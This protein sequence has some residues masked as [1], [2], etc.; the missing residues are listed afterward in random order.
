M[1]ARSSEAPQICVSRPYKSKRRATSRD[2]APSGIEFGLELAK[3][4]RRF[5]TVKNVGSRSAEF[6]QPE[7][8]GD[9]NCRASRPVLSGSRRDSAPRVVEIPALAGHI[10]GDPRMR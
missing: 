7:A 8:T 10:P 4:C 6:R 9:T 5:P 3:F 2:F 1:G